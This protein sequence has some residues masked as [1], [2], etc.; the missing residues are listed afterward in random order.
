MF[1]ANAGTH[2]TR[3]VRVV[4]LHWIGVIAV[5]VVV[6]AAVLIWPSRRIAP[7][8]HL[9]VADRLP[10]AARAALHTQMHAHARGMME[11]VSTVT[12]LDYEGVRASADRVLE[13]PRVAR[14][15]GQDASE[16]QLPER[17]FTLQDDLRRHLGAIRQAA[18]ARDPETLSDELGAATRTCVRC[19]EAYVSGR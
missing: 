1:F 2:E 13:E 19:H 12:V 9:T 10:E 16:L 14:P 6:A 4:R 5:A 7:E 8:H 17:F 18:A 11:L 3:A 15:L